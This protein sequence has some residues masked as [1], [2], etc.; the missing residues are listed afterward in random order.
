M[1]RVKDFII[2]KL[3]RINPRYPWKTLDVSNNRIGDDRAVGLANNIS[4]I[5]LIKLNLAHDFMGVKIQYV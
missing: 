4:W 1:N 2:E 5:F 3:A